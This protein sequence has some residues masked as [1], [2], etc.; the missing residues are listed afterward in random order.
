VEKFFNVFPKKGNDFL[1]LDDF[2]KLYTD[3]CINKPEVVWRNLEAFNYRNDLKHISEIVDE[4]VDP[5]IL[6]RF[7]LMNNPGF[8][9]NLFYLI[10]Q[11]E[12]MAKIAWNLL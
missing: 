4:L 10:N 2:I 8:Y 9:E 3:A 1:E 6:P 11:D 5:E 12:E 7:F